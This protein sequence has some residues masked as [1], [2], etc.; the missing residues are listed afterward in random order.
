MCV[1]FCTQRQCCCPSLSFPVVVWVSS[2]PCICAAV[3]S[4]KAINTTIDED[5]GMHGC[6]T[7]N[8]QTPKGRTLS[9]RILTRVVPFFQN[10]KLRFDFYSSAIWRFPGRQRQRRLRSR[11]PRAC[12]RAPSHPASS[13]DC[14][15]SLSHSLPIFT[16]STAR[17]RPMFESQSAC[18]GQR[19]CGMR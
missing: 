17:L 18:D 8:A 2:S 19:K 16:Q 12:E 11:V 10:P 13:T 7:L 14:P 15:C 6:A 4:W 9:A 1:F 5:G 3:F